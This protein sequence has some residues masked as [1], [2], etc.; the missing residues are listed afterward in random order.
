MNSFIDSF[1][2]FIDFHTFVVFS[3]ALM[4]AGEVR[5]VVRRNELVRVADTENDVEER[6]VNRANTFVVEVI[7]HRHASNVAI[8]EDTVPSG[9]LSF[10]VVFP[11]SGENAGMLEGI[12][13]DVCV[14]DKVCVARDVPRTEAFVRVLDG[15]DL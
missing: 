3:N 7:H 10:V 4:F 5:A 14:S 13:T 6:R 1:I 12:R 11:V 8:S 15:A 9:V 2:D